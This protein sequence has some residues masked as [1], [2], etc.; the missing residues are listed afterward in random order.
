MKTGL[1]A[2]AFALYASAVMAQG[3]TCTMQSQEKKLA[4]AAQKS[5]MKKCEGDA[6]KAC[7]TDSVAKRLSG[8]TKASHMKKCVADAVGA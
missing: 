8:A 6:R 7:E 1:L 3:A 2:V 4:G 5:F